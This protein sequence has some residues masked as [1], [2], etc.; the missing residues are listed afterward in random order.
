[1]NSSR[2]WN[3]FLPQRNHAQYQPKELRISMTSISVRSTARLSVSLF[4]A[5]AVFG[6]T[7]G[8][9]AAQSDKSNDTANDKP[10]QVRLQEQIHDQ[11]VTLH[12]NEEAHAS[13]RD[14]GYRWAVLGQEYANTGDF[15][16]SENAYTRALKLL[17]NDSSATGLYADVMDQMGAVYRIYGRVPEALNCRRKALALRLQIGDPLEIARSQSHLA[18]LD[19]VAH[20]NKEAARGADQAY[21]SMTVQQD[22]DQADLVSALVVL[23]YAHCALHQCAQGL[24]DAQKALAISRKAFSPESMSVAASLV[25]VGFAQMKTGAR[26]EA[27][28]STDQAV[29]ILQAKLTANDPRLTHT[30]IQYRDCLL[31]LHQKPEAEEISDQLSA[32][33]RQ[34][35]QSCAGCTVSSFGLLPQ[36]PGA[37]SMHQP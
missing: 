25:A 29:H 21:Q 26:E 9:A 8:Y 2:G 7:A 37:N 32:A 6:M 15:T 31:A 1:M 19:L 11:L 3:D 17:G 20:H 16:N 14:L 27:S 28:N 18:E 13:D 33:A 5:L 24:A 34:S 30:L 4:A 10:N 22:P 23:S 36:T 12:A 35:P